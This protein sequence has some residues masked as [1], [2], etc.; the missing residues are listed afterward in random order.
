MVW[1]NQ[2]TENKQNKITDFM[3]YGKCNRKIARILKQRHNF[4]INFCD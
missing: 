3:E 1:K 4:V 2:I